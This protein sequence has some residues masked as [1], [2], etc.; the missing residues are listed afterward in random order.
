MTGRATHVPGPAGK[1]RCVI[2]AA[3]CEQ[4]ALYHEAL[5]SILDTTLVGLYL[6]GSGGRGEPHPGDIDAVAAVT[7]LSRESAERLDALHRSRPPAWPLSVDCYVI[8][9]EDVRLRGGG[10][11]ADEPWSKDY[12]A[13]GGEGPTKSST[14]TASW[15]GRRR[16]AADIGS[17]PATAASSLSARRGSWA[18][19]RPTSSPREAQPG[20][21]RGSRIRSRMSA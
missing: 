5:T 7:A 8:E 2:P 14:T 17:S 18:A 1:T 3:V 13:I 9:V 19:R 6:V 15:W 12:D 21:A 20:S 4:W 10:A 16:T 11:R